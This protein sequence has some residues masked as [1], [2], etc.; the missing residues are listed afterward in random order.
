MLFRSPKERNESMQPM[1]EILTA[2]FIL[3]LI[4]AVRSS[5]R[6]HR[7]YKFR[8]ATRKLELVLQ[9]RETIKVICPQK[10]GR[11]ILTSKRVLF[12]TKGGFNAVPIK[13]I[14]KVQGNNEKGNRTTV[15]AKMVSLTIKAEQDYE[16]KNN[17]DEFEAFAKQLLKKTAQKKNRKKKE[18]GK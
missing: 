15:P 11:V 18:S 17:C 14:K 7:E 12:E 16:I 2:V 3:M 6:K 10:K 8:D 9:P 4:L 13:T 1:R 5:L